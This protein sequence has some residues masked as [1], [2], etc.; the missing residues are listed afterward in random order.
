MYV[1]GMDFTIPGTQDIIARVASGLNLVDA[2][3]I[4]ANGVTTGN[5]L[6]VFSTVQYIGPNTCNSCAN[7]NKYVFLSRIYVGNKTLAIGGT[8]VSSRLGSPD[9][10]LWS[11]ST[12]TVTQVQTNTGAQV[13]PSFASI[14]PSNIGD[15]NIAYVIEVFFTPQG[16]FGNG[17]FDSNGVYTRVVM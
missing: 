4:S 9:S 15:G 13:D 17:V 2:E 7:L 5:G 3:T 11:T 6:I 14:W 16:G 10:S 1:K 8:T 12:G